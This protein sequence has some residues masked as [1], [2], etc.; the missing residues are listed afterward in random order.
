MTGHLTAVLG[1]PWRQAPQRSQVCKGVPRGQ[2]R[3]V[4]AVQHEEAVRGA[5]VVAEPACN[6]RT[7]VASGRLLCSSLVSLV[8]C[9]S[10]G[11]LSR[12]HVRG[13]S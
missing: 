9:A 6:T 1:V 5:V 13:G 10:P 12:F 3:L 8:A 7:R 2:V 11:P 4:A